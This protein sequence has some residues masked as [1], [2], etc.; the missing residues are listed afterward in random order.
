MCSV[1]GSLEKVAI[2]GKLFCQTFNKAELIVKQ[3]ILSFFKGLI[4]SP[5]APYFFKFTNQALW[6]EGRDKVIIKDFLA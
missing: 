4:P 2:L 1:H 6:C 3:F 5:F